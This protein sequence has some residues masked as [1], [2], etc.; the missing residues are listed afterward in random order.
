[1]DN[2]GAPRSD[3]APTQWAEQT[4]GPLEET[5]NPLD[6]AIDG[7][8]YFALLD[9]DG[10][11]RFT[12]AGD[13]TVDANQTLRT[14]SG[15]AVQGT[16]GPIQVPDGDGPIDVSSDGRLSRDG[17]EFGQLRI[18]GFQ[19]PAQLERLDGA[20]FAAEGAPVENTDTAVL[21]GHL[22]GSNVDP[23]TEMNEMITHHRMFETQQ[24]MMR[25]SDELLGRVTRD[26]G[27][28]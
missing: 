13:F 28:F 16:N 4:P 15:F 5:G 3:R 6:L 17:N 19:N 12:R 11:E 18:V 22:E 7:D 9:S 27:Q 26:L 14:P 25:T 8:G 1:M 23:V 20:T 2:E 10:N 21:Q 24:R